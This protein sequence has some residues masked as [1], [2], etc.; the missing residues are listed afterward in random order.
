MHHQTNSL[1]KQKIALLADWFTPGYKAGGPIQSC[2]NFC[3]A[4]KSE[5]DIYVVTTNTDLYETK[6]Y[7]EILSDQWTVYLSGVQAYYF[8]KSKLSYQN[9]LSVLRS[10]DADYI[11]LNHIFSFHFVI[12]PLIMSWLRQLA[13]QVV[14]A[15]RGALFNGALHHQNS[16]L[17]KRIFLALTRRLGIF[18]R[19]RFH[20]T[21]DGER[22][23][24]QKFFPANFI[25]VANNFSSQSQT[26]FVSMPKQRGFLK[27]IFAARI[28]PIK[29]LLFALQ[30]LKNVKEQVQL[31][32]VGPIEDRGYWQACKNEI[33]ALPSH[34]TVSYLGPLQNA[35][36]ISML[37]DNHIYFLPTQ[38]E[39]FGHSIF[40]AFLSG[41][42][43]LISDQTPWRDL[44]TQKIG[45]DISLDNSANFVNAIHAACHW[46]QEEFDEYAYLAWKFAREFNSQ[47]KEVKRYKEL[48]S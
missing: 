6:P 15:P 34:C 28:L 23:N 1:P 12:Q 24:I 29:N 14:I 25:T 45:W 47:S 13:A 20:A 21:N 18:K 11:Y 10:C 48:F 27:L 4:M 5:Y 46:T 35:E 31:T 32:I 41:R 33:D 16:F 37:I 26:K 8:S 38:S 30:C 2:V 9:L 42:P 3:L 43:V 36:L 22:A 44:A 40:E 17:K 7:P 39:N 19:V